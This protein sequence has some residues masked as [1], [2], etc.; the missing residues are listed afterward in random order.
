MADI[1][2]VKLI[3]KKFGIKN[4]PDDPLPY[5]GWHASRMT[6]LEVFRDLGYTKGAEIGVA[7]GRF[8]A[9]MVQTIPGLQLISV[10]PWA[11]YGNVKQSLC[12]WRYEHAVAALK[13]LGVD[14]RRQSSMD[15]VREIPLESLDFIYVDGN[16]SFDYVMQDIIEW[17][18][19]VRPGGCV[20]GHDFYF[21]HGGG[22]VGAVTAYTQAHNINPWYLTGEKEA[23]FLWLK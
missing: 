10:D 3:R 12:D 13:P 17:A 21:F 5:R 22:V 23:S 18:K 8:S 9:L 14:I 1:D 11:P 2:S 16:H 19:R 7:S 4:R 6:L 20:S 15:A